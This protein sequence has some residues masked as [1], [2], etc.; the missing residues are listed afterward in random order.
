MGQGVVRVGR[1]VRQ[2]PVL[3]AR[4]G[5]TVWLIRD[6][7][8]YANLCSLISARKLGKGH[9]DMTGLVRADRVADATFATAKTVACRFL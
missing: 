8:G 5:R 4:L 9:S 3:G 7:T 2:R 6:R 1:L